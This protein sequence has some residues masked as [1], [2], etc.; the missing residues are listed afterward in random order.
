MSL[1]KTIIDHLLQNEIR[2]TETREKIFA[3][4]RDRKV[5]TA[6]GIVNLLGNDR[7]A[8]CQRIGFLVGYATAMGMQSPILTQ[9]QAGFAGRPND[10]LDASWAVRTTTVNDGEKEGSA[11]GGEVDGDIIESTEAPEMISLDG[12]TVDGEASGDNVSDEGRA[13]NGRGA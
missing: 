5:D 4:I 12:T 13:A 2:T 3:E 9:V 1:V 6:E 10:V 7:N 11:N 8:S